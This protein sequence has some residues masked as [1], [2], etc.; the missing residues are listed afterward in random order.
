MILTSDKSWFYAFGQVFLES[1]GL[2]IRIMGPNYPPG[3]K[4]DLYLKPMQRTILMMNHY[5]EPMEDMPCGNIEGLVGVDQFLVKIGT[6]TT[7]EHTHNRRVMKF[8]MSPVVR[9]CCGG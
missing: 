5:V 1:T 6:V 3:K 7:F 4:E 2:K 9:G 8:N